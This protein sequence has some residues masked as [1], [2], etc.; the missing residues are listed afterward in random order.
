MRQC[1]AVRRQGN[2]VLRCGRPA[3]HVEQ[4]TDHGDWVRIGELDPEHDGV[5][6]GRILDAL[7]EQASRDSPDAWQPPDAAGR[8]IEPTTDETPAA[9]AGWGVT[10]RGVR[11]GVTH[12][13]FN[14]TPSR[15]EGMS[16][17]GEISAIAGQIKEQVDIARGLMEQAHNIITAQESTAAQLLDGSSQEAAEAAMHRLRATEMSLDDALANSAIVGDQLGALII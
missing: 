10:G 4:L 14:V 7:W 1:G 11:P 13:D 17:F 8:S 12:M 3:I 16:S 15:G 6:L 5:P 9:H 2:D